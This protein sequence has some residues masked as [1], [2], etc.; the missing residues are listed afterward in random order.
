[1]SD[2]EAVPVF[3][4]MICAFFAAFP[5]IALWSKTRD[6]AW[7]FMVLGAL[8]LFIDALYAAPG[9]DRTGHLRVIVFSRVSPSFDR[10]C[11]DC[12]PCSLESV[13]LYFFLGTGGID[14]NPLFGDYIPPTKPLEFHRRIETLDREW[15]HDL[16]LATDFGPSIPRR[17]TKC[18]FELTP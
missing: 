16:Y 18:G 10:L 1:M 15:P 7:V 9:H 2:W 14:E 12:P 3:V 17:A 5:A 6:A 11:R 13:S 8:F 4:R